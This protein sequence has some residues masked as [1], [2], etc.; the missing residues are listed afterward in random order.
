[1]HVYLGICMYVSANTQLPHIIQK[2][3]HRFRHSADLCIACTRTKQYSAEA[4]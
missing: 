2:L 3:T 1:M 4:S